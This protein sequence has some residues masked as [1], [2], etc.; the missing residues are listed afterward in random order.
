[1]MRFWSCSVLAFVG[2]ITG[3]GC[4]NTS[5]SLPPPKLPDMALAHQYKHASALITNEVAHLR[6]ETQMIEDE[7]RWV[8]RLEHRIQ[9]FILRPEGLKFARF[10]LPMDAFTSITD[11][12]GRFVSQDRQV[13][14]L[15]MN[16]V[17]T[18]RDS[19]DAK[20][21][22]KM[23]FEVPGV[24]VGGVVDVA[25][26]R[27]YH[28]VDFVE[29]W[30]F[31]GPLPKVRSEL[32]ISHHPSLGIDYRTGTSERLTN[33][34]PLRRVDAQGWPK[35]V[36]VKKG[37]RPFLP[38]PKGPHPMRH[39]SWVASVVR[40]IKGEGGTIRRNDWRSIQSKVL[41]MWSQLG[42]ISIEGDARDRYRF[43]QDALRGVDRRGLGLISPRS[44]Q[45][46]LDGKASASSRDAAGILYRTLSQAGVRAYPALLTSGHGPVLFDGFPSLYGL[47]KAVVA[48]EV[49]SDAAASS[50]K[51]GRYVFL[52][53]LCKYCRYG[54]LPQ[55]YNGGRAL[56]LQPD[57]SPIWV[58]VPEAFPERNRKF[59]RFKLSMDV[60]G[61]IKGS[62]ASDM[63][64]LPA[65]KILRLAAQGE[66]KA[67]NAV[68]FG[69]ENEGLFQGVRILATKALEQALEIKGG[70]R[71]RADVLDY[72]KYYLKPRDI[73]GSAFPGRWRK[74]RRSTM[75]LDG[76]SWEESVMSIV[77]PRGYGV[78]KEPVVKMTSPFIE[79]ASG[80]VLREGILEY[81]RRIVLKRNRIMP[82][83]WDEFYAFLE[84]IRTFEEKGIYIFSRDK[85]EEPNTEFNE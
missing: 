63:V 57:K 59:N 38:E 44:A 8:A 43:I 2:V 7:P 37:I 50:K 36:F 35:L 3:V 42:S 56:I 47:E 5:L 83:E 65:R 45:E 70:L 27:M 40:E 19:R 25:Y 52:D 1:M 78:L 14:Q 33:D 61:S 48:V 85:V 55:R 13:T 69:D 66:S 9:I 12:V 62:V 41:S 68:F 73:I 26:T 79:Y 4:I 53:P 21:L 80:F 39:G 28:D 29:P 54:E 31:S 34:Q 17:Q 16:A 75:M 30:V 51:L 15:P 77:L 81:S 23:R 74:T 24:Q 46:L 49:D 6:Y 64:G 82:N 76:P 67:V 71:L 18:V 84:A 32:S 22:R 58:D 11:L 20:D 72:E 60:D 10:E